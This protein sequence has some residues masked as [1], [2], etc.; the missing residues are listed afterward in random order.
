MATP[1]QQ[2]VGSSNN[3]VQSGELS[4]MRCHVKKLQCERDPWETKCKNC[5]MNDGTCQ[6]LH[7]TQLPENAEYIKLLDYLENSPHGLDLEFGKLRTT[8]YNKLRELL[9]KYEDLR[10]NDSQEETT[11]RDYGQAAQSNIRLVDL[12][13]LIDGL[14]G[15][16]VRL[17]INTHG[18]NP[19]KPL[20]YS[21][22]DCHE[23]LTLRGRDLWK[24]YMC[25]HGVVE[26]VRSAG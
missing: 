9:V 20:V 7:H 13:K 18:E 24:C 10:T 25:G 16:I 4:C 2:L 6:A 8:D 19:P 3:T 22:K 21:C 14:D 5:I 12:N 26:K 15:E 17:Y 1:V 23:R 11:Q